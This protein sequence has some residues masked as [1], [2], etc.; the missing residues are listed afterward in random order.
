M[1]KP[2]EKTGFSRIK[3]GTGCVKH[4]MMEEV[5]LRPIL[6]MG[7]HVRPEKGEMNSAEW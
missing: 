1:I 7:Y 2:E 3:C 5:T 6:R 4:G